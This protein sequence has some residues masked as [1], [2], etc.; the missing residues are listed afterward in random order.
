MIDTAS[1]LYYIMSSFKFNFVGEDST[2]GDSLT[3]GSKVTIK[4]DA[5]CQ[6][7]TVHKLHANIVEL[8]TPL[9]F[10][11]QDIQLKYLTA[12]SVQAVLDQ[13]DQSDSTVNEFKTLLSK[14]IGTDLIPCVYEGGLVAWEGAFDLVIY[15]SDINYDFTRLS[16]LELGCGSGLPALYALSK[17]ATDVSLQDYNSEVINFVTIPSV[18]C[19]KHSCISHCNFYSGS[20]D[21][22]RNTIPSSTSYDIILTSE[23]I[24]SEI[25]QRVLLSAMKTLLKPNGK[26]FVAAKSYYFGVG[27]SIAEFQRLVREDGYFSCATVRTIASNVPR[28]VLTLTPNP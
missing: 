8:V 9:S 11:L 10:S 2:E 20:W 17:G 13:L 14:S 19:N 15:L 7:H 6:Q 16:V 18:L 5:P 21:T 28:V 26:V 24:Y 22:L 1:T 4:T 25:S 27:G 23:T 12:A 3:T